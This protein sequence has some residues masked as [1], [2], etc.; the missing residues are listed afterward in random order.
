MAIAARM[1]MM[2]TTIIS[3][4]S[5]KPLSSESFGSLRIMVFSFQRDV[6][7]SLQCTLVFRLRNGS[8]EGVQAGRA[9]PGSTV[10]L[11]KAFSP[12]IR[13]VL[14]A[15]LALAAQVTLGSRLGGL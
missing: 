10:T 11:D 15:S 1:P 13:M 12:S 2:A 14:F 4:T 8:T 6:R 5:V 3:S 7:L 9:R